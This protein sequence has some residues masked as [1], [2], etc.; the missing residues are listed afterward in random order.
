[1]K[2]AISIPDKAFKKGERAAK[3][4]GI[5]R[6]EFYTQAVESYSDLL[7]EEHIT[8]ALNR[9]YSKESSKLDTVLSEIQSRSILKESW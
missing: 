9:V 5:S 4:L 8:E 6:S 1:M 7:L 3:K 2:T